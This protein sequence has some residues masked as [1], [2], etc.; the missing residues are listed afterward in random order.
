MQKQNLTNFLFLWGWWLFYTIISI[1]NFP[2]ILHFSPYAISE[3]AKRNQVFSSFTKNYLHCLKFY[4]KGG[5]GAL[6]NYFVAYKLWDLKNGIL[7]V[8]TG[9]PDQNDQNSSFPCYKSNSAHEIKPWNPLSQSWI[10][11]HFIDQGTPLIYKVDLINP[12]SPPLIRQKKTSS[13]FPTSKKVGE[14][15]GILTWLIFWRCS[16]SH[17]QLLV[18]L[19]CFKS[20]F[21][22]ESCWE[23]MVPQRRTS[24]SG[25]IV[26]ILSDH[27]RPERSQTDRMAKTG[28]TGYVT[29]G[30]R[31]PTVTSGSLILISGI[32]H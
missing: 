27:L 20:N 25:F 28:W 26:A 17:F 8:A 18:S 22:E 13:F 4:K 1:F 19:P 30:W 3:P 31:L 29:T 6:E 14:V 24:C 15:L 23:I 2:Y 21:R 10:Q 5:K 7:Q 9:K 11:T 12:G 32:L 16:W